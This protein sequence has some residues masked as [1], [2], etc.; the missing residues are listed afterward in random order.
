MIYNWW[1][2]IIDYLLIESII[3]LI[4]LFTIYE[5]NCMIYYWLNIII[6]SIESFIIDLI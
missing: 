2:I 3:Y 1:N 4:Q 6:D 5:W